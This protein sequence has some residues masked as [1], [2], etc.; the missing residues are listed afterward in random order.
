MKNLRVLFLVGSFVM[1]CIKNSASLA[2]TSIQ[3]RAAEY[4]HT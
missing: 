2:V 3:E 4:I 1:Y